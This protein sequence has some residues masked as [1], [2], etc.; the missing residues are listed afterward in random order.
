[1]LPLPP[2]QS[3]LVPMSGEGQRKRPARPSRREAEENAVRKASTVVGVFILALLV[4]S[5]LRLEVML[6]CQTDS[7]PCFP[8]EQHTLLACTPVF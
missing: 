4:L 7:I 8:E 5:V 6:C 1:M 3:L 2:L